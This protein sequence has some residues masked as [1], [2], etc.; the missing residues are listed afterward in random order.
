MRLISDYRL[1]PSVA[2]LFKQGIE[3]RLPGSLPFGPSVAEV[4]EDLSTIGIDEFSTLGPPKDASYANCL[5]SGLWLMFDFMAESHALSQN[6]P[7]ASGSYWH[8]ILHR[9]EPD[10]GNARY[11]FSRVG[12]HPIFGELARDAAEII[13][14]SGCESLALLGNGSTWDPDEFIRLCTSDQDDATTRTLLE[15]QRREWALLFDHDYGLAF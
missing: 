2:A 15:I 3:L 10:A 9:R 4:R 6:I 12:E 14:D 8:G 7:H 1:A 11:W 13:K 5:L